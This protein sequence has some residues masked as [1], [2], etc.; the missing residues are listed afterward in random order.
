VLA[1]W[2]TP[3]GP[4]TSGEALV[5]IAAALVL[6]VVTATLVGSR[7][8]LVVV[9]GL[10]AVAFELAR[11]G[12]AGPTVDA[13]DLS[14][15]GL[16]AFVVG[17]GA[18][19][20]LVLFPLMLGAG[21]GTWLSG[22]LGNGRSPRP[23]IVVRLVLA[24]S[25]VALLLLVIVVGRPASTAPIIG[26]DGQPL[27]GSIAELDAVE[28]GGV[29]QV[30]MLRGRDVGAPVL[31][32]LAGGPGGTDIG[33]M[34][35]DTG[36]EDHFVVVTWDQRGTGKS[37]ATSID[38]VERLTFEQAVRDTIEVAEHLRDRFGRERI[39]LAANSWGTI[40]SV[41]AVQQRPEL[42][43]AYIG[44]GQMVDNRQTDRMF[45]E[46]AL[47][48]ADGTGN[49]GLA[50]RMRA[51][52][53]PPYEDLN[54]YEHTVSYEHQWNAYPG[55]GDLSEMP[56]NTFV[57]ENTFM[58]RVNAMRGMFDV[59]WFVYP[60]LQDHDF[61][62]DVTRLAVPVYLVH[63]RYEARGRDVPLRE[64][65]EVLEAPTKELRIFERSGHRPT[66]E[67][68][69]AFV[70]VMLEVLVETAAGRA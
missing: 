49:R 29:E 16:L 14:M 41:L 2:W 10:F 1:G 20:L 17:R 45:Y 52:G 3:R 8:S 39:Y 23:G 61:R 64:W 60:Q 48:W 9:P 34:R 40:P 58:D 22:W 46:D 59:N 15:F 12:T 21:W 32:H 28:I 42:F 13:I 33:A 66:F 63:G 35:A 6:G 37:Y 47:A 7:W 43:H 51:V 57:P 70:E 24:A 55:V 38:P 30:L 69:A 65:F 11:I 19:G 31:L 56:F 36:L 4:L 62:R 18:H 44:S 68:P 67:Q 27:P 26:S 53:L 5:S 25:S 50:E 54:N